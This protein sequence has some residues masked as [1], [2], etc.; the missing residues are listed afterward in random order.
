LRSA[1]SAALDHGLAAVELG[2]DHLPP[3]PP[4]LLT[5]ARLAARNRV[6]LDTVLRRYVAASS[7]LGDFIM[8]EATGAEPLEVDA[9]QQIGRDQAGLLDRILAAVTEEHSREL[10]SRL[11]TSK[12]RR[13]EHI[14][15][16]L[17]GET[18]D[19]SGL[20]YDFAAHH[21]GLVAAGP[22]A[23]E[24]LSELSASLDCRRL[25]VT[26]GEDEVWAWLGA[27]RRLDST[28]VKELL[29]PDLPQGLSIALGEPTQGLCGWG[30]THR[31]AAAC[32]PIAQ[33]TPEQVVR[34]S[35]VALLASTLR[36]DLLLTSLRDIYLRPLFDERDG[37][38]LLRRTLR[39][40]FAAERNVSSAA[41]DLGVDRK[42]VNAR[43][44]EIERRLDRP[45]TT[46]A[47]QLETA[48]HLD[49]L[50]DRPSPNSGILSLPLPKL[51]RHGGVSR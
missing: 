3:V 29:T 28:R 22:H 30:L 4:V 10:E 46:C 44:R 25:L 35:D 15:R 40:Y 18:L 17:A 43:L 38:E 21:L 39:A 23:S 24:R 12:Q 20:E 13:A 19:T 34:Y 45:I 41:A 49:A 14:R 27:G 31:Q 48:L 9:I 42:T 16:L 6:G 32:L 37:G 26:C 50:A 11:R 5:E 2:A 51:T 7:I 33:R 36:D 8:Q 1:V 47:A